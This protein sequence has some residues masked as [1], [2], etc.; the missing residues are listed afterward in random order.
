MFTS[1]I[2]GKLSLITSIMVCLVLITYSV[3]NFV[4]TEGK[5]KEKAK[6]TIK[7]EAET[8][9]QLLAQSSMMN[10]R[11]RHRLVHDSDQMIRYQVETAV[12]VLDHYYQK[13]QAGELT[14]AK[15]QHQAKETIRKMRYQ[16]DNYFWIDTVNY[17][18]VL[19]PTAP[20]REGMDRTE[21]K[22]KSGNYVVKSLVDG[23]IAKGSTYYDYDWD[24]P[25]QPQGMLFP[26][27]GYTQLFEPWGWVIG[28]GIYVDQ[29]E[30]TVKEFKGFTDESIRKK[31]Q[32]LQSLGTAFV[33]NQDGTFL[34]YSNP[35]FEGQKVS[36]TDLETGEDVLQKVLQS[37][38]EYIEYTL[39]D[40]STK[41]VEKRIVY[42]LYN[43]EF[44][45]T[46][47][48]GANESILLEQAKGN[49]LAYILL[50]IASMLIV[51]FLS[52]LTISYFLKPI[53]E[54]KRISEKVSDG[55]LSETV[56]IKSKDELGQLSESFNRMIENLK[57]LIQSSSQVSLSVQDTTQRLQEQMNHTNQ[58]ME[59]VASAVEQIS[60]GTTDQAMQATEG[61]ELA[62]RLDHSATR[63]KEHADQM[64]EVTKEMKDN[65]EKGITIVDRLIESQKE[66]HSSFERITSSIYHLKDQ[67]SEISQ[68]TTVISRIADQTN[69][70]A[71]NAS[72][73]AAR[74]GESGRGFAVVASE[75]RK[76]A[77]QSRQAAGD[78]HNLIQGFSREAELSVQVTA[79]AKEN[80]DKQQSAV[81]NTNS[82]FQSLENTHQRSI[83][84]IES[85]Y[86]QVH[87][88]T[89]AKN[90][91]LDILTRISAIT[92]ETA[93]S[94]EEVA[95][96]AE[97]QRSSIALIL[98]EMNDL[99]EKVQ[100]MKSTISK[101]HL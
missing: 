67:I 91:V 63:V 98:E 41:I 82:I 34:F 64:L 26:K 85:V 76:L 30:T 15:A 53:S 3:I 92:Q 45:Y 21:V 46:I 78:I 59:E 13:Q 14:E 44:R 65:S 95:A 60:V 28:T 25:N 24:K 58:T 101:F 43:D 31:L 10:E 38:N 8:I 42:V 96:S 69:L 100:E 48:V 75:V 19:L 36:I 29:I 33:L 5:L 66:S 93:A 61:L 77:E 22:D 1:S 52:Y 99:A 17:Q 16:E 6:A 7:K 89:Q 35:E 70:L 94:T 97:G 4:M 88:L 72:I 80:F 47:G 73:E 62:K 57:G 68:F 32:D 83:R 18:L 81:E 2:K 49:T 87:E 50:T 12:G 71:L 55:D 51:V 74:A 90:E 54:L 20:E 27:R 86:S 39:E 40:P 9:D 79:A 11:L 84:H 37:Q 23:A 56:R